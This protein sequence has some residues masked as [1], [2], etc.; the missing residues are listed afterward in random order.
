[1]DLGNLIETIVYHLLIRG[2]T[3]FGHRDDFPMVSA[4]VCMVKYW[5]K[6]IMNYD[7]SILYG[8]DSSNYYVAWIFN[9]ERILSLC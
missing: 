1:M 7:V 8:H 2:M 4:L 3:Y 9:L 5:T 6:F